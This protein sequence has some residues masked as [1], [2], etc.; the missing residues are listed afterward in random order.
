MFSEKGVL[1]IC[2]KFT[3]EHP[4]GS[5]ISIKS[6]C[7]FIEIALLYGCLPVNLL[8]IFRA[9]FLKN[10]TGGLLLKGRIH[11]FTGKARVHL[12][13]RWLVCLAETVRQL[14]FNMR[15]VGKIFFR[16][17][18]FHFSVSKILQD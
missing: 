10:T 3:G 11:R 17:S 2:R 8:H 13:T 16:F 7:S 5:V 14:L 4:C 9:L 1:K 15:Y 18:H 12:R 6:L